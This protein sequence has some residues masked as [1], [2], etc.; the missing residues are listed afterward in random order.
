MKVVPLPS[1]LLMVTRPWC[2]STIL[3]TIQ[4]PRPVLVSPSVGLAESVLVGLAAITVLGVDGT[5]EVVGVGGR[6]FQ[7][8]DA[9]DGLL[10]IVLDFAAEFVDA[11]DD[12]RVFT[13]GAG[14]LGLL[15]AH[16]IAPG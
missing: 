6:A 11:F 15:G 7:Q 5:V 2:A 13:P 9:D 8:V 1:A 3:R 14:L 12:G 16:S 10:V 4:S